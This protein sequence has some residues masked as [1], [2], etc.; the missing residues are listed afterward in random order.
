[1]TEKMSEPKKDESV[2]EPKLFFEDSPPRK[3]TKKGKVIFCILLVLPAYL[4]WPRTVLQG[5]G[6]L[7]AKEFS[8]VGLAS[9]GVLKE[10]FYQKGSYF[11]SG[12]LIATFENQELL[13]LCEQAVIELER[14]EGE[15]SLVS[16]Q[17]KYFDKVRQRSRM[18]YEN[19]VTAKSELEK[20]EFSFLRATQEFVILEKKMQSAKRELDYLKG[21]IESLEIKAPFDGVVLTDPSD[22][23]GTLVQKGGFVLE[24]ANPDTY[25]LEILI[26]ENDIE[27]IEVGSHVQARFHAFPSETYKGQ[28]VRLAPRTSQEV[29]KV[30]KV[31]HVVSCEIKLDDLPENIRYGMHASVKIH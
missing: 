15:K 25:F 11:K 2:P 30:F 27:K 28:V 8:K 18:L 20:A 12:N 5:D 31:R 22:K 6:V 19:G 7:Q 21:E 13:K 9:S 23:I 16:G 29:E 14:L 4:F 1:M 10:M 3:K 17:M 24:I 26:P